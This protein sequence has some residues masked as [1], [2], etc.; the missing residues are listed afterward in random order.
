MGYAAE[1]QSVDE[2][3]KEL[4]AKL[5]AVRVKHAFASLRATT[6]DQMSREHMQLIIV[7]EAIDR[8][9]NGFKVS[10][11]G[12]T[13]WINKKAAGVNVHKTH[14]FNSDQTGPKFQLNAIN[15]HQSKMDREHVRK[16][17]SWREK[18]II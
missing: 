6:S 11:R 17:K 7:N 10:N 14:E 16:M 1:R 9:K 3:K 12:G 2:K 8:A 13:V 5:E 15:R 18:G 4:L